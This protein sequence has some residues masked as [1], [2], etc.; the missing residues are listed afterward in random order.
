MIYE[1][2]LQ[3][4]NRLLQST[5]CGALSWEKNQYSDTF[6]AR[7]KNGEIRIEFL[8]IEATNQ[9]GADR[10]TLQL[11]MPGLKAFFSAG[12]QGYDLL[13]ETFDAAFESRRKANTYG[14]YAIDFLDRAIESS[15]DTA[16]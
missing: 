14:E 3:V 13:L 4:L 15:S 6:V 1:Q 9:I 10:H 5:K 16:S 11:L 8:Y 7:T 12:T 2:Q